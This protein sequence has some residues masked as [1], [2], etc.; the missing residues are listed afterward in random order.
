MSKSWIKQLRRKILHHKI[1]KSRITLK[2][3]FSQIRKAC[4]KI[5]I[6]NYFQNYI[7]R[8]I[9]KLKPVCVDVNAEDTITV[10]QQLVKNFELLEMLD[11]SCKVALR[12]SLPKKNL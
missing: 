1:G 11:E 7:P 8:L 3:I 6:L 12:H 9:E 2:D 5:K 4:A 10:R